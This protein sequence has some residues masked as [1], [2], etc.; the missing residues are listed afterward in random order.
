MINTL[1]TLLLAPLLRLFCRRA[2]VP[3]QRV[4]VIQAAK[5]GDAICTSPLLR[6]LRAGLPHAH[7][8]VLANPAVA[9]LLQA[10]PRIDAIIPVTAAEWRGTLG[11]LRLA[12]RL[13]RG[14]FDVVFCCNGGS[15]WPLATLWA[16][17]P[18]RI[19]VLPNFAGRSQ[20]LAGRLWSHGV[21][22]RGDRLIVESYFDMLRAAGVEPVAT[23]KEVFA[24]PAAQERVAALLPEAGKYVGIAVSAANKL[25]ELESGTL[26]AVAAGLL[27]AQPDIRIV[28]LG[29]AGDAGRAGALTGALA[30]AQQARLIDTCGQ[31]A[32]ADLPALLARLAAF[33]GVDSG[34]TYMADA[35][36]L[37]LVSVAG[38]CNMAETRPVNPRAAIIQRRLPCL[39]CAHIF[40]APTTCHVGTLACIRDVQAG[41]IVA[42][43]LRALDGTAA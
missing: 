14:N 33:V 42:A 12:A 41:E 11:K 28:L 21:A 2:A 27:D 39:P 16:G 43:V 37:P 7:V 35:L 9:P 24:A 30:P 25:K 1:L 17:I 10:N 13:R 3:P 23:D 18:Q 34:L 26:A 32:L 36:N 5:I 20:R 8:A 15:V 4:L 38:P 6:E 29:T 40:R 19:G 31:V 22:H